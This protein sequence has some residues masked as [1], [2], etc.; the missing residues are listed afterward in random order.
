MTDIFYE[1]PLV[2]STDAPTEKC[3]FSGPQEENPS[4]NSDDELDLGWVNDGKPLNLL[5]L[6][7]VSL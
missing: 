7:I 6:P 4:G 5:P 2:K 3:G 1:V